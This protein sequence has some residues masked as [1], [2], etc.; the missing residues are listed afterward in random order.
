M[1]VTSHQGDQSERLELS[2]RLFHYSESIFYVS[3]VFCPCVVH[4]TTDA[5]QMGGELLA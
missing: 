1:T 3:A 2:R 4:D 5:L